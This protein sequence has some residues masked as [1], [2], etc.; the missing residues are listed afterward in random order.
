VTRYYL[1]SLPFIYLTAALD[2]FLN[3]DYGRAACS[4]HYKWSSLIAGKNAVM[5]E[6]P[7]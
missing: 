6:Y 3:P 1:H 5:Q 4:G 2:I 7:I